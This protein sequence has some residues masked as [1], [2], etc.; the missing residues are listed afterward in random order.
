MDA[1]KVLSLFKEITKI[2]RE[3]AHEELIIEYLKDFAAKNNLK[4]KVDAASN[5]LITREAHPSRKNDPTIVLQAHTDMVCEKIASSNHDFA[6]DPINYIIKDGWMIAPET[7]LGADCGIGI[8]AALALLESNKALPKLECLFTASEE[9]GMDG[10]FGLQPAFFEG[11]TLIN[12][13]SEDEGE[14]FVGCSGGITTNITIPFKKSAPAKDRK[15][16]RIEV[17]GAIGGHS[18]DDINKHR[19][20]ALV[21]LFRELYSLVA[22]GYEPQIIDIDGGGKHNAISREAH[23]TVVLNANP[24]ALIDEFKSALRIEYGSIEP[25]LDVSIREVKIGNALSVKDSA[26]FIASLA[27]APHGVLEMSHDIPG[28]VETSTNFASLHIVEDKFAIVASQRSSI[29]SACLAAAEKFSAA[30]A[31]L[32]G[33]EIEYTG[34]YPGWKP[35]LDSAILEKTVAAYKELF[36]VEPVVRAIH[37]GLE[38]GLFLE[39]YPD[40]DMISF[41][42]TLRGVHAPGERLDLASLEKFVLLL[43]KVLQ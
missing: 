18:G 30:F 28:L 22:T 21:L 42:P 6:K 17:F 15:A 7:T 39:K 1:N 16:Y 34:K 36:D 12:L 32:S 19:A 29:V 27:A 4:C 13:D 14:L 11:K 35:N 3:S 43:N 24:S 37:A 10:A 2:P 38:C 20:S 8:A 26:A 40:L 33:V 5:V 9:T 41:G 23:A 25:G 31:S